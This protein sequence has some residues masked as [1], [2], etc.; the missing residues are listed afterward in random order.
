MPLRS[1]IQ[2]L[3]ALRAHGVML[4][5]LFFTMVPVE[6]YAAYL[7]RAGAQGI[8]GK[9][10]DDMTLLA[11]IRRVLDGGTAFPGVRDVASPGAPLS[12][13]EIQV[14]EGLVR[15]APLVAIAAEL[16]VS[17]ASVTTYR[18]RILEKLK[19]RSN[20]ELIAAKNLAGSQRK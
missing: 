4:P 5:I 10:A 3:E 2:V 19:V 8:V 17:A 16:G 18:R 7:R 1:G 15:G 12:A 13:R 9:D 20:A 14:L 11:A 6:Q